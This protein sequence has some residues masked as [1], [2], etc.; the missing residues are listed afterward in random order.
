MHGY[1][2]SQWTVVAMAIVFLCG[3]VP[4]SALNRK[5]S[6]RWGVDYFPNIPL[7]SHEGKT[8]HFFDDLI[9][10]LLYFIHMF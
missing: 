9:K 8:L 4:V 6:S 3:S 2:L 5:A 7:I 1:G 10:F